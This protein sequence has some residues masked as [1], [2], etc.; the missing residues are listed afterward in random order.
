M[1]DAIAIIRKNAA[2]EIRV[3]RAWPFDTCKKAAA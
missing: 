2:D 3:S 1:S